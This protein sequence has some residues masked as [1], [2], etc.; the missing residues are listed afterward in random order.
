[1][2]V[3]DAQALLKVGMDGSATRASV[4]TG[5][6]GCDALLREQIG[7]SLAEAI[8][9]ADRLDMWVDDESIAHL[10]LSD[11][12]ALA[13]TLN[14]VATLIAN[15]FGR[16]QPVFGVAVITGVKRESV[17]ALDEGQLAVVEL[18]AE[19]SAAAVEDLKRKAFHASI[20]GTAVDGAVATTSAAA[21]I[22]YRSVRPSERGPLNDCR[23]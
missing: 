23:A 2:G 14:P 16:R 7:C 8:P 10:D 18:L 17:A 3:R 21:F 6:Q 1:M 5:E 4:E 9:L 20:H 13:E 12:A 19:M 22:A 11:G 15:H